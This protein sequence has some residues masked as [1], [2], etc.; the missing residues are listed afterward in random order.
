MQV[1]HSNREIDSRK[2]ATIAKFG[3][4]R[5]VTQGSPFI[6]PISPAFAILASLREIFRAGTMSWRATRLR[7]PAQIAQLRHGI[8]QIEEPDCIASQH[9]VALVGRHA[10]ECPS[11]MLRDSGQSPVAWAKSHPRGAL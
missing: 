4:L 6:G 5:F 8:F 1:L 7:R 11:I 2:G 10:G 9:S 3:G